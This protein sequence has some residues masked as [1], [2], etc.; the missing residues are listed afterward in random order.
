MLLFGE[1]LELQNEQSTKKTSRVKI[2]VAIDQEKWKIEYRLKSNTNN[3][4]ESTINYIIKVVIQA[5]KA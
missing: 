5:R 2:E 3:K 1:K 4:R